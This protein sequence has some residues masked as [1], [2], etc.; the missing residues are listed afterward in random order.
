MAGKLY[1]AS[2]YLSL[3]L[4]PYNASEVGDLVYPLH[5]GIAHRRCC[6]KG[7]IDCLSPK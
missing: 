7:F 2:C 3:T 1:C 4:T 6:Q 5:L